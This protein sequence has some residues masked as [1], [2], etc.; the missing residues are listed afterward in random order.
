MRRIFGEE[1]TRLAQLDERIVLLSGDIGYGIFDDFR[2]K[3]P[4]RFINLGVM[5]QSMVSIAAGMALQGLKP[6]VYT[7][8]PFLLERAYEQIKIDVDSMNLDIKL[9]GYADYPDQ[10]ITH[11]CQDEN[12]LLSSF[13]HIRT[14]LPKDRDEMVRMMQDTY[15][16]GQPAFFSLKKL[17]A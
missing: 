7:I 12:L 9:V 1:L 5:E 17:K 16:N 14:C 13:S 8:T 2:K 6:Y 3:Y 15:E 10:G 11:C 4:S